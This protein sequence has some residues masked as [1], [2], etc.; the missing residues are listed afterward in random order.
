MKTKIW[1]K[2]LYACDQDQVI[3]KDALVVTEV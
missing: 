1:R 3:E 2:W